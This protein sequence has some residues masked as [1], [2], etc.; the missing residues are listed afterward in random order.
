MNRFSKSRF[1]IESTK[2]MDMFRKSQVQY[3]AN[4]RDVNGQVK[5]RFIE[6]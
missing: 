2:E 1:I 3:R 6:E 4:I 5:D